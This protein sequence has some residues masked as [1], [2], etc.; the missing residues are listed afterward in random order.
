MFSWANFFTTIILILGCVHVS[1]QSLPPSSSGSVVPVGATASSFRVDESGAATYTIP[2]LSPS[3]VAGVAPQLSIN[4]SSQGGAGLVG[5]GMNLSGLGGISRCRQTLLQDSAA[6]PLSWGESDR[7]CLNGQ[8][9]MLVSGSY[10]AAG[11]TYKTEIDAYVVVTA[12]GGRQVI[13]I[14]LR[15]KQRMVQP[16]PLAVQLIPRLQ[17][18]PIWHGH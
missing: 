7:F 12:R 6:F 5:Y 9:L 13:L 16:V 8:R 15:W 3:G 17:V 4:Y 14:I 11:S 2:I 18:L 1:A 10:G